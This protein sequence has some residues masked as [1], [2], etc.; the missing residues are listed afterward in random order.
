MLL[1]S[2]ALPY[3]GYVFAGRKWGGWEA[4]PRPSACT[5]LCH[6]VDHIMALAA[7]TGPSSAASTL[8]GAVLCLLPC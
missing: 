6:H 4:A 5:C 8:R 1:Y 2:A 7:C 3:L